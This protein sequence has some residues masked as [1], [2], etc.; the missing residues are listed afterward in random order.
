LLSLTELSSSNVHCVVAILVFMAPKKRNLNPS[1]L[2]RAIINQKF[3]DAKYARD[4]HLYTTDLDTTKLKSVTHQNDL[5]EFLNTAQL[6]GT[7]FTAEK[8]NITIVQ[9]PSAG[10]S[11]AHNPF[12]LTD[13]EEKQA[14]EKH[15]EHKSRLL[16]PR[17]PGWTKGMTTAQLD[18]QE[19]DAFL[20]WRRG[21][22]QLVPCP[23]QII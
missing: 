19:R 15:K 22:A 2:G 20:D 4:N 12:L 16:V 11:S 23:L 8:H 13:M 21:L 18:R 1:G 17:R 7:E 14:L 10:A 9:S 6:A 5:D 3:K